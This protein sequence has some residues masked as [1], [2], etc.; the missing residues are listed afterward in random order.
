[1]IDAL[2]RDYANTTPMIFGEAPRFEHILA[3][4]EEIE[5]AANRVR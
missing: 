3:S 5:R 2:A 4:M 1:M